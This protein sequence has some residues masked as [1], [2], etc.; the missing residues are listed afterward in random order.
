MST[1]PITLAVSD[2]AEL[3]FVPSIVE[4]FRRHAPATV[5]RTVGAVGAQL[6]EG[7]E[8]GDID[9]IGLARP[10]CTEPD[11]PKRLLSGASLEAPAFEKSLKLGG[12]MFAP[13][14]GSF[15]VKLIN[16]LGQMGW[17]Y[18]QIEDLADGKPLNLQRGV[19]AAFLRYLKNEYGT[20]WRMRRS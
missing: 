19:L 17:Y 11:L 1:R 5:V 10:L 7:L 20:A 9:V 16:L 12:G 4:H 8:S 6:T 3:A 14:S 15:V 18:A 13:S 2:V